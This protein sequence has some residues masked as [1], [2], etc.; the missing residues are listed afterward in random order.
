[1]DRRI[2]RFG[3]ARSPAEVDKQL[4]LDDIFLLLLQQ[5]EPVHN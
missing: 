4:Q 3:K 1:M 2:L 5:Y